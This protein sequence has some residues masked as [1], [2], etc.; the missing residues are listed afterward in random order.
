M[1]V[2]TRK[3][4][5]KTF[6]VL[7]SDEFH[8]VQFEETEVENIILTADMAATFLEFLEEN[9]ERFQVMEARC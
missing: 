2:S 3:L 1:S 4:G 5:E 7:Y 6:V 8:M 9:R